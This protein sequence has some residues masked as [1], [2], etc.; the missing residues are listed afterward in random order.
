MV[1][2]DKASPHS[3]WT[4]DAHVWMFTPQHSL[5]SFASIGL[6]NGCGS[7]LFIAI[8][9]TFWFLISGGRW[10]A[11]KRIKCFFQAWS[12]F[13][14]LWAWIPFPRSIYF[15]TDSFFFPRPLWYGIFPSLPCSS[16]VPA[17]HP[18]PQPFLFCIPAPGAWLGPSRHWGW[19]ITAQG[20]RLMISLR[21]QVWG[22]MVFPETAGELRRRGASVGNKYTCLLLIHRPALSAMQISRIPLCICLQNYCHPSLPDPH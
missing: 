20:G 3:W 9:N 13:C 6:Q 21:M 19:L 2:Y 14:W 4:A 8:K 12:P 11:E 5:V 10:G 18:P 1:E 17:P 16:T 15:L 7:S 22:W